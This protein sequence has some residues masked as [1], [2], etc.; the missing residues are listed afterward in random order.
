METKT[1]AIMSG[2]GGSGKTSICVTIAKSLSIQDKR[3]L[4]IDGD[5]GTC[6]M[7][8]YLGLNL[9]QNKKVGLLDFQKTK[10]TF[11]NVIQEFE[12]DDNI[13]FIGLGDYRKYNRDN[14]NSHRIADSIQYI[15]NKSYSNFDFVIVDCRGGIDKESLNV[16]KIV[17]DIIFVVEPD[18]TS[19]QATQHL[20]ETLSDYN[21]A[22]KIKGFVINKV[23]DNPE[24]VARH[25]SG[26]FGGKFFGAIPFDIQAMRSFLVGDT[27]SHK[28]L[29]FSHIWKA[30]Y[31]AYPSMIQEVPFKTLNSNEY[32]KTTTINPNSQIGNLFIGFLS[33]LLI[34][35]L[36]LSDRIL[37]IELFEYRILQYS[38]YCLVLLSIS[39]F[40]KENIG[41]MIKNFGNV[42]SRIFSR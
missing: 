41:F 40:F 15:I 4:L 5:T 24:A 26:V 8:Y 22:Y 38:L 2:K 42:I 32:N 27:V 18:T 19:F 21:L 39:S 12:K 25:G 7:T 14:E 10:L 23:F 33:I 31:M 9:V 11:D 34:I 1:I 37:E 36:I 30:F 3:V 13:Y 28:S 20:S 6:G 16:A 29:Y 35:I 17:D